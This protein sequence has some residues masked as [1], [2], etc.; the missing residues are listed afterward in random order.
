[1]DPKVETELAP[2]RA[3]VKEQGDLVAKLKETKAAEV[4]SNSIN[5]QMLLDKV[6]F[7]S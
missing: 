7:K 3:S 1:M 2:L 4:S 6:N 5:N